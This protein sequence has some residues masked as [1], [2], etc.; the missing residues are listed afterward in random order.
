MYLWGELSMI[1]R[2]FQQAAMLWAIL[3]GI[4]LLL[5]AAL[6]TTNVGAFAIDRAARSFGTT[7]SALPGYEDSVRLAISCAA[8]MF[9][10]YCQLMRGHV[11]VDVLSARMSDKTQHALNIFSLILTVL[12]ALFL[13]YWML[14][15]M[16]ETHA[17]AAV[18]RVLGWPEWPFYIPGIASLVLWALIALAQIFGLKSK[19]N[20]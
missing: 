11:V 15:G 8:L 18:S 10:P 1:T 19:T 6:T 17:D 12:L 13:A 16:L 4:G 20:D 9:F 7:V 14:F 2:H 3:G 5:I